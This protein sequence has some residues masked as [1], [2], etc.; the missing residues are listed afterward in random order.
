MGNGKSSHT[1]EDNED[2]VSCTHR[3]IMVNF[4]LKT[5][6]GLYL[7]LMNDS[8]EPKLQAIEVQ[9]EITNAPRVG[10][11]HWKTWMA[12]R[13]HDEGKD[14]LLKVKEK[15]LMLEVC[16]SQTEQQLSEDCWFQRVNLGTGEHYGLQTVRSNQYLCIQEYDPSVTYEPKVTLTENKQSCLPVRRMEVHT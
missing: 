3:H 16:N 1:E 6:T 2:K 14:Y 9:N 13:F 7:K 12:F 4:V 15:K 11:I 8:G 5:K 10:I